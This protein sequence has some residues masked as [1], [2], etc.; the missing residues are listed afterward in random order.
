VAPRL[1]LAAIGLLTLF[2]VFA[3]PATRVA[4]DVA[5]N[6]RVHYVS[7]L[8]AGQVLSL[9]PCTA[10]LAQSQLTK[11]MYHART[12]RQVALLTDRPGTLVRSAVRR[13]VA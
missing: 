4:L 7:H 13:L 11:G 3:L 2:A 1:T 8:V 6:D 10:N 5:H 12:P 9:C